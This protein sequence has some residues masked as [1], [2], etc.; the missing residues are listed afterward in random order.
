MCLC[1]CLFFFFFAYKYTELYV[2]EFRKKKNRN[3]IDLVEFFESNYVLCCIV[4]VY[5]NIYFCKSKIIE[6]ILK[7]SSSVLKKTFL[8]IIIYIFLNDIQKFN[9]IPRIYFN[10]TFFV[11]LNLPSFFQIYLINVCT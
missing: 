1:V 4:Q 7:L 9:Q 8:K 10:L 11:S 5:M 6:H 2:W 3:F